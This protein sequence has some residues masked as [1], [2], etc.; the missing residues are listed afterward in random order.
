MRQ[1][2]RVHW[3]LR[4]ASDLVAI[5]EYIAGDNPEAAR[6]FVERLRRRARDAARVPLA[7]RS[8]PEV[9]RE[10][11]REVLLG[12]YRIVYRTT[13]GG[14]EVLTVFEGHRLLPRGSVPE[15]A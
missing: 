14:I 6:R 7:A 8:V 2:A 12:S 11:V 1:R 4:A 10:D 13:K 9:Q 3:T 5:G 15:E